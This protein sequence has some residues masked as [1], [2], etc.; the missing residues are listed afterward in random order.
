MQGSRVDTNNRWYYQG[1]GGGVT[2]WISRPVG[3][4]AASLGLCMWCLVGCL[5]GCVCVLPRPF[6]SVKRRCL[7]GGLSV[8]LR[9]FQCQDVFPDGNAYVRNATGWPFMAHNRYWA[10]DNVYMKQ[11]MDDPQ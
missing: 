8:P 10:I 4:V 11:V 2:N 9:S 7:K 1:V 6:R 3:R 5:V